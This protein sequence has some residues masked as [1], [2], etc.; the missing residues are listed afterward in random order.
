[1]DMSHFDA[2]STSESGQRVLSVGQCGPD[3]RSI[4]RFLTRYFGVEVESADTCD[5]AQSAMR[6]GK[7]SL[8][9]VNRLLD[10]DGSPGMDVI[11]ALKDD[12][13]PALASIP[14]MLVSND[15]DAQQA[16]IA[17]GTVL[18]FGKADLDS[19]ATLALLKAHLTGP[20]T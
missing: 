9:L 8:V 13:D 5:E 4:S 3:H 12:P 1:M 11:C 10:I 19:P 14:V 15:P 6:A 17:K 20:R 18:G 16:A 2:A 7:F